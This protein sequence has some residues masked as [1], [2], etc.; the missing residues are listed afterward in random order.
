[1]CRADVD[2][3]PVEIPLLSEVVGKITGAL[4]TDIEGSEQTVPSDPAARWGVFFEQEE[5]F[6]GRFF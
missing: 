6:V 1:M 4:G 3:P 2:K 5:V